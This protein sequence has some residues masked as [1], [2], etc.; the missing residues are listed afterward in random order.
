MV[1]VVKNL[2]ANAR[3][4][5]DTSSI[6]GSRRSPGGRHGNPLQYSCPENPQTEEA[7]VLQFNSLGTKS[8][9]QLSTHI[10]GLCKKLLVSWPFHYSVR[11]VPQS[12]LRSCIPGL[13]SQLCLPSKTQVSTFKLCIFYFLVDSMDN[14]M[15]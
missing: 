3:D 1:L 11:A 5:R 15:F 7:G 10:P 8:W 4:T 13:S 9:T 2:P 14:S 12:C 6:L